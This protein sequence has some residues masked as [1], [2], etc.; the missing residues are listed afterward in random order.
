MAC[1]KVSPKSG[2]LAADAVARPPTGV[3]GKLHQIGEPSDLPSS[4][5]LT[6]RQGTKLIQIDG[7]GP[8]RSQIGVKERGVGDLIVRVI[9]DILIHVSIQYFH[10]GV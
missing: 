3:H 4:G 8:F 1:A 6:A 2:F 10:G 5:C 7:L 9:M